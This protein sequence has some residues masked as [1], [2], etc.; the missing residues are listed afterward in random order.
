VRASICLRPDDRKALVRDYR[1]SHA[2]A[3]RLRCHILLLLD[4]GQRD[5]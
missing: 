1:G 3:A 4:A 5:L 2:P